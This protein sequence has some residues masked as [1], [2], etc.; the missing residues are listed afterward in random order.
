MQGLIKKLMRISFVLFIAYP[1]TVFANGLSLTALDNY[2]NEEDENYAYT[3]AD[4]V[5]G[6]GYE[7]LIIE[8]TSQKWL[9]SAEVNDPIWR[10]YMTVT[11]PESVE[12]NI[13]FL[14]VTGGS[15]SGGLP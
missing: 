13:S 1:A 10:H 5:S 2:V 6:Q 14:Y 15:K 12:S 11:I 7:T 3:I 4:T 8:M 9:T